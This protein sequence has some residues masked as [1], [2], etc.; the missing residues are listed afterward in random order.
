MIIKEIQ[1]DNFGHFSNFKLENLSCGIN[2]VAGLNEFG[3]STIAEFVTRIFYGFPDKRRGLNPYPAACDDVNYGGRLI[4]E[5][6]DGREVVIERLGKNKKSRFT[7]FDNR[8][9]EELNAEEIFHIDENFYREIYALTLAQLARGGVLEEQ[10]NAISRRLYG[11][12]YASGSIDINGLIKKI[13]EQSDKLF[14]P[15]GRSQEL[16]RNYE[17]LKSKQ[18]E[19]EA[20]EQ[21]LRQSEKLDLE[22]AELEKEFQLLNEHK[23]ILGKH[24]ELKQK[25]AEQQTKIQEMTDRLNQMSFKQEFLNHEK[26]IENL[27]QSLLLYQEYHNNL[28]VSKIEVETLE[29]ELKSSDNELIKL[30]DNDKFQHQLMDFGIREETAEKHDREAGDYNSR[31]IGSRNQIF[32]IIHML[33]FFMIIGILGGFLMFNFGNA[34]HGKITMI[35]S[36]VIFTLLIIA[37]ILLQKIM[38][39]H[40]TDNLEKLNAEFADFITNFELNQEYNTISG[41]VNRFAEAKKISK[42][43][44][45]LAVIKA[46]YRQKITRIDDMDAEVKQLCEKLAVKFDSD[47]KYAE[48]IELLKRE[49]KNNREIVLRRKSLAETIEIATE[50]LKNLEAEVGKLLPILEKLNLQN[51]DEQ[52]LQEMRL[53]V[54][55]INSQTAIKRNEYHE[56]MN[57]S[58]L[59]IVKNDLSVLKNQFKQMTDNYLSLQLSLYYIREGIEKFE[60]EH[61]GEIITKAA[62]YFAGISGNRYVRIKKSLANGEIICVTKDNY[63]RKL[64]ELSTGSREQLLLA[65]RLSLIDYIEKSFEPLPLILDDVFVNFDYQRRDRM[66]EIVKNFAKNRQVLLFKL[67]NE[68]KKG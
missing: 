34:E 48:I 26:E 35:S 57:S 29:K 13:S 54:F 23:T 46:D 11:M 24:L 16:L 64:P 55:K 37:K 56:L 67:A 7:I 1:I 53:A 12:N 31:L 45:K 22:I 47:K 10:D 51:A 3:K 43:R 60:K 49:L 15:A 65:M 68:P 41:A 32:S 63:E 33:T 9:K 8:T 42:D 20:L 52:K 28:L 2:E 27:S 5:L 59:E 39:M 25:I 40:P 61:Q 19:F 30:I 4:C 66:T 14:L 38:K 62:E 17:L 36:T 58:D 44:E 6:T 50:Q 21:K 18:Q